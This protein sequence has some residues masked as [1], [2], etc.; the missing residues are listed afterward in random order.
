MQSAPHLVELYEKGVICGGVVFNEFLW[1]V[2]DGNVDEWMLALSPE[3]LARFRSSL[4][5]SDPGALDYV[6]ASAED[7]KQ[8][9]YAAGLMRVWLRERKS[10]PSAA[11]NGGPAVGSDNSGAGGR[12]PSVS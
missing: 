6:S 10:E 7:I 2:S 3:L 11:P 8:W 4:Q 1:H 9:R 12:P 5:D